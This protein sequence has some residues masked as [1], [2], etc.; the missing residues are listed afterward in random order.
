MQRAQPSFTTLCKDN[1]NKKYAN[2]IIFFYKKLF[3]FLSK[4]RDK[5][6]TFSLARLLVTFYNIVGR[7]DTKLA[8]TA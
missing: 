5:L 6:R 3:K 2:G 8:G 1:K 7:I 4:R